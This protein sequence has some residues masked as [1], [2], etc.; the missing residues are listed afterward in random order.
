MP[1]DAETQATLAWRN[2]QAQLCAADMNI[3]NLVKITTIIRNE[4]DIPLY[5]PA[6]SHAWLAQAR[7]HADRRWPQHLVLEGFDHPLQAGAASD[8]KFFVETV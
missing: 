5:A 4:A 6:G 7:Q 1:E 2:L 8:R 3:E